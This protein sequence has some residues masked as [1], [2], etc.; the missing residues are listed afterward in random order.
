MNISC[1]KANLHFAVLHLRLA[2]FQG[3]FSEDIKPKKF[4]TTSVITEQYKPDPLCSY[5]V[6]THTH[7]HTHTFT[8]SHT[9]R[10]TLMHPYLP[11]NDSKTSVSVYILQQIDTLLLSFVL[12]L[13]LSCHFSQTFSLPNFR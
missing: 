1:Q 4:S 7:T 6:Q 8:Y 2:L 13:L 12:A 11:C 5:P 3:S 9:C 10:Y